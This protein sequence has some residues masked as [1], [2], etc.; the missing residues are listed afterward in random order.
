ML[1]EHQPA[2]PVLI[3]ALSVFFNSNRLGLVFIIKTCMKTSVQKAD[4]VNASIWARQA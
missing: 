1:N 3:C 2:I 4:V